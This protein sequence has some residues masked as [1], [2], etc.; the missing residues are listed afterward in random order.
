MNILQTWIIDPFYFVQE[1]E[2]DNSNIVSADKLCTLSYWKDISVLKQ[3]LEDWFYIESLSSLPVIAS[4]CTIAKFLYKTCKN[5]LSRHDKIQIRALIIKKVF[6]KTI[7]IKNRQFWGNAWFST[8]GATPGSFSMFSAR[9]LTNK[10][11]RQIRLDIMEPLS[12]FIPPFTPPDENVCLNSLL[13]RARAGISFI[14]TASRHILIS[15]GLLFSQRALCVIGRSLQSPSVWLPVCLSVCSI[16]ANYCE[17]TQSS[18]N[19]PGVRSSRWHYSYMFASS[20]MVFPRGYLL[21]TKAFLWVRYDLLTVG[22]SKHFMR[23][24]LSYRKYL[25]HDKK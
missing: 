22:L 21:L 5:L 10:A 17:H 19:T 25:R 1:F 11:V 9:T 24:N 15:L 6:T 2:G 13:I 20:L 23:Q 16:K 18:V 7:P 3:W 4:K 8:L 12:P 14:S